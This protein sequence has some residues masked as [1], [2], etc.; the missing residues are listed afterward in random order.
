M[1]EIDAYRPLAAI[2]RIYLFSF[3]K[4]YDMID[5]KVVENYNKNSRAF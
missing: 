5:S 3:D 1:N 4:K 2:Q